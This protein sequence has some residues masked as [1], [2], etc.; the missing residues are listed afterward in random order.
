MSLDSAYYSQL[1]GTAVL[2]LGGIPFLWGVS[3]DLLA[4]FEYSTDYEILHSA[5]FT[6][7]ATLWSTLT[8]L[9]WSL[10]STFVLEEKHG[11]N[12]QTLK[13]CD[14]FK[15]LRN[16]TYFHIVIVPILMTHFF[17]FSAV[18]RER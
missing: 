8:G 5:A 11:F 15:S 9:P 1:E 17:F 2:L 13:V 16:M 12:K 14:A 4:H 10:Y 18:L 6:L 3:G 7:F